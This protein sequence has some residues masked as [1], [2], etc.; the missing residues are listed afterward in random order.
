MKVISQKKNSFIEIPNPCSDFKYL[1]H[2]KHIQL[3]THT[4]SGCRVRKQFVKINCHWHTNVLRCSRASYLSIY[5]YSQ[6]LR[7]YYAPPHRTTPIICFKRIFLIH[8]ITY[9]YVYYT[10]LVRA[11]VKYVYK[12]VHIYVKHT[13]LKTISLRSLIHACVWCV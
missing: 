6:N 13:L 2:S 8:N 9:S 7:A 4:Q 5:I 11:H 12:Y 1:L 3:S 10:L